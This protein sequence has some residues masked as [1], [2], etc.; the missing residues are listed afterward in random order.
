[1]YKITT[2]DVIENSVLEARFNNKQEEF[3]LEGVII[4]MMVRLEVVNGGDHSHVG[5]VGGGDH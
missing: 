5:K 4:L 1:M 2:I 3:R